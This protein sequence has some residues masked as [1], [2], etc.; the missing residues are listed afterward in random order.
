MDIQSVEQIYT[1]LRN[2]MQANCDDITD[3]NKGS[4]I[5]TILEG[6]AGVGHKFYIDTKIGYDN[7]LKAIPYSVFGFEKKPGLK[8]TGKVKFMATN[9]I[10]SDTV[11]DKGTIVKSGTLAFETSEFAVIKAGALESNLVT[12]Q[13]ESVGIE[14][15]VEAKKINVINTIVPS[16]VVGV[17]NPEKISNGTNEETDSQLLERFKIYINGLQGGNSYGIKS[18]VLTIPGVRSC[19]IE[20]HVPLKDD[21]YSFTVWVDDGTGSMTD[22]LKNEIED[23]INGTDTAENPGKRVAGERFETKAALSVPVNIIV[24]AAVKRVDH[25]QA[26]SEMTR[27]LNEYIN[28][29]TIGENVLISN[30]IVALKKYSYIQSLNIETNASDNGDFMLEINQIARAGDITIDLPNIMGVLEE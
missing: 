29:L 22:S 10:N 4:I 20:E 1:R 28:S 23:V 18:A 21:I 13:A 9:P 6:I 14:Y 26:R 11:I 12:C 24:H 17:E 25:D 7:N 2:S 8:A 5:R 27:T 19:S 3:Y 15:N 16:N 30:L